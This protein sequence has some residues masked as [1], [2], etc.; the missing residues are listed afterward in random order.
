MEED[1]IDYVLFGGLDVSTQG[2]KFVIINREEVIY[3]D[4]V[5]YDRDL[6]HYETKNGSIKNSSPEISESDPNMWIEAIHILFQRA[7]EKLGDKMK[8][9]EGIS[10]SGQQH[11]LVCI[12]KDG[13]LSHPV[14]KLWND[15]STLE[16]CKI[17]T[18]KIGGKSKMIEEVCSIQKTGY[19]ASKIFHLVRH[20]PENF[21]KTKWIL[22][23]H[24]YINYIL[25]GGKESGIC[26]MERGDVS[27]SALW[28]ARTNNWS[29][30]VIAA[31]HPSLK[32][33]LPEV[34]RS[35]DSIGTIGEEFV[36]QYGLNPVCEIC[37]GSGDNMMSAIGTANIE[38]G[39]M[40]LS[41][42]TSGTAFTFTKTPI[43][44]PSGEIESFCDA[45]SH[46]LPLLCISNLAKGYHSF[47]QTHNLT[48]KDFED[49]IHLTPPANNFNIIVPW[50]Q[51]ERTPYFP[52]A[53]PIYFGFDL[54]DI[55]SKECLARAV[56]EGHV[57]LLHE[58]FCSLLALL[59]ESFIL[60]EIR[61]TGGLSKSR[62]W[63]Q[64]IA[65][66]FQSPVVTVKG[67][68][69]ALGAAIHARWSIRKD[70][71]IK[72]IVKK[73]VV[74]EEEVIQCNPDTQEIYNN[75]TL[76]YQAISKRVRGID[77]NDPFI[78][79]NEFR[80]NIN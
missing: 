1:S 79:L 23:V 36:K 43:I 12:G 48:H 31:I 60:K 58:G 66:I 32:Q 14:S 9:L 21:E 7:S 55:S 10:V 29:D 28:N 34:K 40:T 63:K 57:L 78:L 64:T 62:V 51:G 54:K 80:K 35:R 56:L 70:E 72:F 11:G 73:Y 18:E 30:S 4:K 39:I 71:D 8:L 41:L 75:L 33:K 52:L 59:P 50:F 17:L 76:L 69:A 61:L 53:A 65:D 20:Y 46:F 67:E 24:N 68:G 77:G 25:T 19:T 49:L 3:T 2:T 16:E 74:F 15:F 38:E 13:E 45:T 26:V 6:S 44:D 27:G 47:L 37:S 42:G 5:E 22:V